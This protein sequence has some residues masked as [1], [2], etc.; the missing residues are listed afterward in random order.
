MLRRIF[1]LSLSA[2]MLFLASGCS[3]TSDREIA[4][5][6]YGI[7]PGKQYPFIM[8][9]S[10]MGGPLSP[11]FF[12]NNM[13]RS[14]DD[15]GFIY[16]LVIWASPLSSQ[17]NPRGVIQTAVATVKRSQITYAEYFGEHEGPS[18]ISLEFSNDPNLLFTNADLGAIV[19]RSRINLL[20][21]PDQAIVL[22]LHS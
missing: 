10:E 9:G 2:I 12:L 4:F 22:D 16:D 11:K 1:V 17:E 21:T 19:S 13:R 5:S 18:A 14:P 7:I 3:Q 20:V 15:H 6:E 8:H